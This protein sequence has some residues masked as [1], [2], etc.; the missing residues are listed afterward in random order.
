MKP[1][2]VAKFIELAGQE[3][4]EAL[5]SGSPS[6]RELGAQLLL[7]ETLEYVIKGLGV[8][9]SINGVP[10]KDANAL[11]YKAT[12]SP[13]LLEMID[14]LADVAYTMWWNAVTFGVPLD[15][16]YDVVCDNNLQKFV[17]MGQNAPEAKE[18]PKEMWHCNLGVEWPGEVVKVE[19][20][21]LT[22]GFYAVGKDESGKVR[23][24]ST[25]KPVDLSTLVDGK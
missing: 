17:E 5:T 9:P 8:T 1:D 11:S 16:A 19:V 20:I 7:S 23:K 10:I 14:G 4:R 6:E 15:E 21:R 25:Y 2:K 22:E 18:L 13:D 3:R 24:P 12:S